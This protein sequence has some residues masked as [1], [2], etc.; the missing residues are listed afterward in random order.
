MRFIAVL[1]AYAESDPA[2]QA[3]VAEFR[4][5]LAKLGWRES[6]NLRTELRWGA[7]NAEKFKAFA[8]ELVG[9]QP[10]AILSMGTVPTRLVVHETQT[11]PIVFVSIGDPIASG[12]VT[13]LN[14]PGGNITGF[15]LEISGLGGKQLELLKEIAPDTRHV[16][17]LSNPATSPSLQL[18]LPSI[19]AA[20]SSHGVA[21][22]S[23]PIQ[24]KEEI[25]GVIAAEASE[26]GGGLIVAPSA[27]G[28]VN[29]E[30]IIALA[31]KYSLPAMYYERNF[32]DL[33]GLIAYSPDY[34]GGFG[35]A[36]GYVDRILK[37]VKP[38]D[39]PVQAPTTFELSIN[40]KTAK[41]LGLT[42]PPT[43]LAVA[44]KVIE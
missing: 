28:S 26:P 18:F 25:E 39:L 27:F 15:M 32:T 44:D 17:L 14:R 16:A 13:N 6:N 37:G 34:F 33:G 30:L 40:L 11:I 41:A 19:Q 12:F 7:G 43:I 20:A 42:I 21:L 5:G 8:K 1:M 31:A 24:L 36:A 3:G 35:P 4:V 2:A 10:D 38:G 9:L 29:R 23:A 22:K